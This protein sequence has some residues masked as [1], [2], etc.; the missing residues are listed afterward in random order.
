MLR[1]ASLVLHRYAEGVKKGAAIYI[2][3]GAGKGGMAGLTRDF[4]Y[5]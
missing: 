4:L 2:H 3:G 5:G 1:T